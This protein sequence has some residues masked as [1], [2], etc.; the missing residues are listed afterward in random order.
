MKREVWLKFSTPRTVA[1][2]Q[3]TAE[4]RH[5]HDDQPPCPPAT[6]PPFRL[7][8]LPSHAA[9]TPARR[10]TELTRYKHITPARSAT[11]SADN[12]IYVQMETMTADRRYI[13]LTSTPSPII[14]VAR[15]QRA[16]HCSSRHRRHAT[17]LATIACRAA[18]A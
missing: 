6:T 3:P 17:S 15:C 8:F 7:F 18:H 16:K 13:P 14:R 11:M 1:R 2:D 12:Y 9:A 4:Y 10:R 5:A